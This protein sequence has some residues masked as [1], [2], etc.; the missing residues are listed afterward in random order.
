MIK[1]AWSVLCRK[2]VINRDTNSISLHDCLEQIKIDIFSPKGETKK[3]GKILAPLNFEIVSFWAK[4]K[5]FDKSVSFEIKIE[6]HDPENKKLGTF[7]QEFIIPEDKKRLR[8][9]I[10]LKGLSLTSNGRYFIKIISKKN[11]K[12]S[13]EAEL[14]LDVMIN[15]KQK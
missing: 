9:R 5:D 14:P 10:N 15:F 2:S 7:S 4:E 6:L 8:T 13:Q 1:H 11:K 12:E 3:S